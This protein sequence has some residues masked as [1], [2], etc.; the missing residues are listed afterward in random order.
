MKISGF[1]FIRNGNDLGYP[2]VPAIRSLLPL[3]DEI[4]INVPESDDDSRSAVITRLCGLITRRF[5]CSKA[6]SPTTT[7][8]MSI[9]A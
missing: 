2:F 6:A 3:C 4:I 1:S 8:P 5:T 9:D 7:I